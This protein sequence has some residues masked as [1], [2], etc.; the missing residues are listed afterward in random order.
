MPWSI[1][2]YPCKKYMMVVNSL[3][4]P[5]WRNKMIIVSYKGRCLLDCT[6]RTDKKKPYKMLRIKTKRTL[7]LGNSYW[8]NYKKPHRGYYFESHRIRST[9]L[10]KEAQSLPIE[11]L[12]KSP[13][14]GSDVRQAYLSLELKYQ[15][16]HKSNN[17]RSRWGLLWNCDSVIF[18]I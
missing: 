11:T 1:K 8:T 7:M 17:S 16:L 5:E 13:D 3:I 4:I 6:I 10:M 15:R 2:Y 9:K 12:D 14:H 18:H